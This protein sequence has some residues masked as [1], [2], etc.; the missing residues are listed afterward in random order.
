MRWHRVRCGASGSGAALHARAHASHACS[1][2]AGSRSA[3]LAALHSRPAARS[4]ADSSGPG[5]AGSARCEAHALARHLCVATGSRSALQHHDRQR[6]RRRDR[7]RRYRAHSLRRRH[8]R[9]AAAG[10]MA[11]SRSVPRGLRAARQRRRRFDRVGGTALGSD[12]WNRA[13]PAQPTRRLRRHRCRAG[14][15]CQT[16]RAACLCARARA[17]RARRRLCA[18][19]HDRCSH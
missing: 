7:R 16:L 8:R 12:H 11:L 14:I 4:T 15:R 6:L 13:Q 10:R 19:R 17:R 5:D 9:H 1:V 2:F 3:C 18:D